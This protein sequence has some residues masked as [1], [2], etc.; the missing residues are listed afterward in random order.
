[1][2]QLELY[3]FGAGRVYLDEVPVHIPRRKALAMLVYLTMNSKPYERD[4]LGVIFWPESTDSRN[5]VRVALSTLRSALGAEWLTE[6]GNLVQVANVDNIWVD[7]L[8]FKSLYAIHTENMLHCVEQYEQALM[9]VQGEFMAGFTLRDCPMFD[10]WL[11][12]ERLDIERK[13]AHMMVSLIDCH[14]SLGNIDRALEIAEQLIAGDTLREEWYCRLMTLHLQNQH[15][16]GALQV[17]ETCARILDEELG[18]SPGYEIEVLRQQALAQQKGE[19]SITAVNTTTEQSVPYAGHAFFGRE[20]EVRLILNQLADPNHRLISL[21]GIGG[22][23]KTHLAARIHKLVPEQFVFKSHFITLESVESAEQALLVL[24]AK[25]QIRLVLDVP[26]SDQMI[27]Q[28]K[29]EN[30]L[31]ILDNVEQLV[32]GINPILAQLVQQTDRVKLLV[33]SRVMLQLHEE[34][35]IRLEGLSYPKSQQP[36]YTVQT[37]DSINFFVHWIQR[38]DPNFELTEQNMQAVAELCRVF[39]GVPLAIRLAAVWCE[40]LSVDELLHEIR[41]NASMLQANFSDIPEKHRSMRALFDSIWAQLSP[42]EQQAFMRLAI[43]EGGFNRSAAQQITD[44]TPLTLKSLLDKSLLV[45]DHESK[46]RYHIQELLRLFAIEQNNYTEDQHELSRRYISFYATYISVRESDLKG[47]NQLPGLKEIDQEFTNIQNAWNLAIEHR[48][49]FALHAMLDGL[50]TYLRMRGYWNEGNNLFGRAMVMLDNETDGDANKQHLY[51]K[52]S[53][54]YY[55][56]NDNP[57][58]WLLQLIVSAQHHNDK[59][60]VA[61]LTTELG[62]QAY[63]SNRIRLSLRY[64]SVAL[65]QHHRLGNALERAEVL[66]GMALCSAALGKFTDAV[67]FNQESITIRQQIGDQ[68]GLAMNHAL[69]GELLLICNNLPAAIASMNKAYT[70][71]EENFS[72]YVALKQTKLL[73]WGLLFSGDLEGA[74]QSAQML[75]DVTNTPESHGEYVLGLLVLA[76]LAAIDG[77]RNLSNQILQQCQYVLREPELRTGEG[78]FSNNLRLLAASMIAV[79]QSL[80]QQLESAVLIV[81]HLMQQEAIARLPLVTHLL[82]TAQVIALLH[83]RGDNLHT[84]LYTYL[85][86]QPWLEAYLKRF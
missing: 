84:D 13:I 59:I 11:D 73:A 17:Y 23:G 14:Q 6:H 16:L 48:D 43:F 74:R 12:Y 5:Q 61:H 86:K 28:L 78:M 30:L 55:Q 24:A 67:A 7:I 69:H 1:M 21:V 58:L 68:F 38:R 29:R 75:T 49:V 15:P 50:Y 20:S 41:E 3:L 35:V 76:L 9:L 22:I 62:W 64:F 83:E 36:L 40:L 51:N 70:F 66:R 33:T 44:V 4:T 71:I 10:D 80:N 39:E 65:Y 47:H 37:Y 60:E 34:H 56:N 19:K 27:A 25:L 81:A 85:E 63:F 31:L 42:T 77:E 32:P 46:L 72:K 82:F 52:L 53:A 57:L 54:R 18:L 8:A 79:I 2:A 45:V 26:V